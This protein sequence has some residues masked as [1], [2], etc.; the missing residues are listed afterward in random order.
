[1]L[2]K[3]V[4]VTPLL[5]VGIVRWTVHITSSFKE[6]M[7]VLRILLVE[8]RGCQVTTSTKPPYPLAGLNIGYFEVTVVEMHRWCVRITLQRVKNGK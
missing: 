4:L 6:A 5:E 7:E 3:E 1:M 2:D 8:E